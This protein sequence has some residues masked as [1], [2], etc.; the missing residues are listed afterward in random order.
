MPLLER[1]PRLPGLT[2]WKRPLL[3]PGVQTYPGLQPDFVWS[4]FVPVTLKED[5]LLWMV[6]RKN[7][8]T[9]EQR[10]RDY[11]ASTNKRFHWS[12][13]LSDLI[14]IP[15]A[16]RESILSYDSTSGPRS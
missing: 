5:C 13:L 14:C 10:R 8:Q 6:W 2:L 9:Y 15:S 7:Y 3:T 12:G 1:V 11:H 16:L 4:L